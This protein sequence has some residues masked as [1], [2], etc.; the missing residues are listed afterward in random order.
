MAQIPTT[1][2]NPQASDIAVETALPMVGSLSREDLQTTLGLAD[3][4]LA[5][6]FEDRNALLTGGGTITNNT[7][8]TSLSFTS[9]FTLYFNSNIAGASPYAVSISSS[10]WAFSA[11]GRMAYVTVNRTGASATLTTD[12]ATLPAQT[13]ANQEIFLIAKRVG[14]SIIMRNGQAIAASTSAP[15]GR[16][17][18]VFDNE[19]IIQDSSDPTKQIAFDASG[20]TGTK[21]ILTSTQTSNR[22]LNLPD[23][24]DTLVAKTTT[25]VLTNKTLSF[26]RQSSTDDGTTTGSN[27]SLAAF[28]TGIVRLTNGSLVSVSAAGV[29]ASG[30]Q[31]M[32]ENKTG[33]TISIINEDTG[34]TA[35]NRFLTGTGGNVLMSANATLIFIYDTTSSRWQL[36]GGSGSG[37]GGGS[38]KNYLSAIA[39]SQS[40]S[41][42]TGN[43]DFEQGS[44]TGWSLGTI[45][46]L[47]NGLPTG[48]PTFGSGASGNLSISAVSSGQLAGS[49][50]LSYAS[51]A[52]TTQGN[53]LASNAFYID[54]EDQAKV[55]SWKFY[56]KAQTNPSNANW[57]GT[58]SNSFA[59]A[60]YDVTNSAW[61][62][63][64]GNF[65]MTQSS[66]IGIASGTFQTGS[67]TSQIRFVVYNAN[68]TSG[69]TTVYFDDFFVGPQ[70]APIGPVITDWVSFIPTGSW[71]TNSTYTGF[72]KREGDMAEIQTYITLAGAPNSATL[73]VN[74]PSGLTIDTA[75][76]TSGTPVV[77]QIRLFN[78]GVEQIDG[79]VF[80][81]TSTAVAPRYYGTS[82]A[83]SDVNSLAITQAAPYTIKSG[84]TVY[85]RYRVPIAGWSSQVQMSND[86]DT[87]VVAFSS[88]G[89]QSTTGSFVA[90]PL[91]VTLTDTHG[92]F[93]GTETYKI[94]VT[95]IYDLVSNAV[96]NPG[97]TT[98]GTV[99]MRIR[100]NG[101]SSLGSNSSTG[102]PNAGQNYSFSSVVNGVSLVAGDLIT[103]EASQNTG[104]SMTTTNNFSVV[105]RSGPSVIAASETVSARYYQV[106]S[107]SIG[108]GG[109][110]P[111]A[112]VR[113]GTRINFDTKDHDTHNSV[114]TGSG[115][116]FT[117]PRSGFYTVSA[118]AGFSLGT[119]TNT[120]FF[121]INKNA[122]LWSNNAFSIPSVY[123]NNFVTAVCVETI[124]LNAGDILDATMWQ[125]SGVA[126]NTTTASYPRSVTFSIVSKG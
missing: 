125:N 108:S 81:S 91:T 104:G 106:S 9:A 69:A 46:T 68:A 36:A 88:T 12:S 118:M 96:A 78:S 95:G 119:S 111:A 124:Y 92:T 97:S 115:W 33:N 56:Y 84:D 25:D 49:Y 83:N 100:K 67:S 10:P 54:T 59:V 61:L 28:N 3:V 86:T 122:S 52:A 24:S 89:S 2:G 20:T 77:G 57:S 114:V 4:E 123:N 23:I 8:G 50:S 22:V 21:T 76:L 29:G 13:S 121:M 109:A 34:Q 112:G 35:A 73:I 43:G 93:N 40:A 58:S 16:V 27:A 101:A 116:V 94:P 47:T 14:T 126:Q 62:G 72:Y 48:S 31:L 82:G 70:T 65:S 37:S 110:T 5:K 19:F 75:K 15:L 107:Q 38:G 90:I 45:G 51:S 55:L 41:P 17:G 60:V 80:F 99:T 11:D 42:N 105:R 74:L 63:N 79:A 1:R 18:A 71:T 32:I 85:L 120:A 26:L 7:A 98:G 102:T 64:V 44:T 117:A 113:V 103:V 39:T 53:M 66:G 87:R 30:Q 6:L